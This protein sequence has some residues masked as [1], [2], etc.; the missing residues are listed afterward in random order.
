M[1]SGRSHSSWRLLQTRRQ[2]TSECTLCSSDTKLRETNVPSPVPP[3]RCPLAVGVRR[4]LGGT[5]ELRELDVA[6]RLPEGKAR[7]PQA[8][9][10][11]E[12]GGLGTLGTLIPFLKGSRGDPLRLPRGRSRPTPPKSL[13]P[14]PTPP[15]LKRLSLGK[16]LDKLLSH[17]LLSKVCFWILLL[18]REGSRVT[19]PDCSIL[20]SMPLCNTLKNIE[21]ETKTPK[22]SPT[23]PTPPPLRGFPWGSA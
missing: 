16:C 21:V 6:L 18:P 22:E 20:L 7:S 3:R 12:G 5:T 15:S 14:P 4:T 8:S 23:P 2:I 13:Q 11:A 19:I 9:P 1:L 10:R 17:Y